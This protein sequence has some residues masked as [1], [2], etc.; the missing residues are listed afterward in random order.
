MKPH[1]IIGCGGIAWYLSDLIAR[2][3][4]LEKGDPKLFLVDGDFIEKS[5]LSRQFFKNLVG[6]NKASAL[7]MVL[8]ERFE[9]G[10]DII[11]IDDYLN[12]GTIR[13]HRKEWLQ[14]EATVFLCVDN[15]PTRCFLEEHA[16]RLKDI[17]VING[18]N[19]D[20]E[21][22][23]QMWVRRKNKD[24]IPRFTEIA[25]EI[26][27]DKGELPNSD[28]CLTDSI[29]EPQTA[30]VNHMVATA[31]MVLYRHQL[32]HSP[33]TM[34]EVRVDTQAGTMNPLMLQSVAE[35]IQ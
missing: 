9:P 10:V 26:K 30:L 13:R 21:G 15:D 5:N 2:H 19:D 7:G 32:S 18:G 29:S 3:L 1:V 14:S 22:Q 6:Q 24:L 8:K 4:Y 16:S 12:Q 34:N 23:A 27:S 11:T 20:K 35:I 17:V 31:M 25:P 33:I 28:H